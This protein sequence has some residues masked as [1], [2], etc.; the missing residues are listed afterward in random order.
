[1]V[2]KI[3]HDVYSGEDW[4]KKESLRKQKME[5]I[6]FEKNK[7]V[8]LPKEQQQSYEKTKICYI[9]KKRSYISTLMMKIYH[10]DMAIKM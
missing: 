8:P 1:M 4:M 10:I 9:C 6:I 5:I 2:K 3:G 7:I